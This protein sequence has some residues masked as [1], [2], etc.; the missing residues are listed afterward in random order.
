MVVQMV[1][2]LV[3][4]HELELVAHEALEQTRREQ[5][6]QPPRFRLHARR[7]ESGARV[8][9]EL[10]RDLHS[11]TFAALADHC[12]QILGHRPG[13]PHRGAEQSPPHPGRPF[14]LAFLEPLDH[15]FD[16][17]ILEQLRAQ[18]TVS[19]AAN[20]QCLHACLLPCVPW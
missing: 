3:T 14:V 16:R 9:V 19:P 10:E 18:L 20:L 2:E 17:A 12:V 1:A 4:D 13:E 15:A 5:H 11:E 7:V 8:D 6:E